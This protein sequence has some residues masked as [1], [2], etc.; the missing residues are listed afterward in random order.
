MKEIKVTKTIEEVVAY[1]AFDGERFDSR[2]ECKKYES[3]AE[4][5]IEKA[6]FE[7]ITR[8]TGK[9]FDDSI[10]A[11]CDIYE[12]FGYGSEEYY[13]AI[14]EIKDESELEIAN[15]FYEIK[16]GTGIPREYIGKKILI[17]LGM[18]YDNYYG[19]SANPQTR[20]ALLKRFEE[21]ID[22]YFNRN[23]GDKED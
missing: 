20:E 5:V 4:A 16:K 21:E 14:V 11:E 1:E 12:H 2:D 13:Y 22:V 6:F 10:I 15:R 7:L 3:T 9:T 23:K 17:N 18:Q 8:E 19:V